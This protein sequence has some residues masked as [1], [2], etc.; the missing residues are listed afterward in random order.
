MSLKSN[1]TL[2]KAGAGALAVLAAAVASNATET[3]APQAKATVLDA[4]RIA[5]AGPLV[6]AQSRMA[7]MQGGTTLSEVRL[8]PG[9]QLRG[10]MAMKISPATA[11]LL[12]ELSQQISQSVHM[13]AGAA[14]DYVQYGYGMSINNASHQEL[15]VR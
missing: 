14:A 7:I 9:L 10:N 12:N 1:H 11:K 8:A 4:V 5:Q 2:L 3:A 15:V 6:T 13:N